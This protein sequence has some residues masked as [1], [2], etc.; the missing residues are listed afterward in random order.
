[1]VT[2]DMAALN[3]ELNRFNLQMARYADEADMEAAFVI[4]EQSGLLMREIV[5][6]LPPKSKGD[7]LWRIDTD[8]KSVFRPR[9]TSWPKSKQGESD[10][11][12]IGAGPRFLTG[13]KRNLYRPT[14]SAG[15][16][17]SMFKA[18][19]GKMGA[20]WQ[21][22]AAKG[23]KNLGKRGNQHVQFLNRVVVSKTAL[24]Q[25]KKQKQNTVGRLKAS[26]ALGWSQVKTTAKDIPKWIKDRID[27]KT[28]KG[29]FMA[30]FGIKGH[31]KCTIISRQGGCTSP[32][33]VEAIRKALVKR[34][35]KIKTDF[36]KGYIF[37]RLGIKKS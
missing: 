21:Q 14:A 23:G 30:E 7:M 18:R 20:A 16:M 25:F 8:I 22:Q 13:V 36:E 1:M 2:V 11:V 4:K 27:D 26:F 29:D 37:K 12:W 5:D 19:Y 33:S 34:I 17:G 10:V 9:Y 6:S 15:E 32:E 35:Y 31:P 24:N 28:A 3:K